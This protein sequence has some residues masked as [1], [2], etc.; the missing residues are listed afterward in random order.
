L[1]RDVSAALA[2]IGWAHEYEHVTAEGISLDMAQPASKVAVEFDGPTHYLV[3]SS[4]GRRRVL[5]GTSKFKE[6]LLHRLGW[7]FIRVP[8]FEWDVLRSSAE[9]EAYLRDKINSLAGSV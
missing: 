3:G 2:R 7:K 5:D 6:K 8:Y 4:D 9:R 1:Q